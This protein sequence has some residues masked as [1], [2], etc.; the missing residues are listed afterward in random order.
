MACDIFHRKILSKLK[1]KFFYNHCFWVTNLLLKSL[2]APCFHLIFTFGCF[3]RICLI[4]SVISFLIPYADLCSFCRSHF[5]LLSQ[6]QTNSVERKIHFH[7]LA[8]WTE[9]NES[10][11]HGWAAQVWGIGSSEFSIIITSMDIQFLGPGLGSALGAG[12]PL[13][14]PKSS[15]V[16]CAYR[17]KC[18]SAW[19]GK[20][21]CHNTLQ[22]AAEHPC[23][24]KLSRDPHPLE[25][26]SAHSN[27]R[28]KSVPLWMPP[29]SH[30]S[31]LP[32]G[33]GTYSLTSFCKLAPVCQLNM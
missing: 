23:T 2:D 4:G 18:D 5:S 19:P 3:G 33:F 11:N 1:C 8:E 27:L 7:M 14:P 29:L 10:K 16:S 31:L 26:C 6:H 15:W 25:S 22:E 32:L 12:A 20:A 13:S 30:V 28:N 9:S 24:A 17:A 21:W